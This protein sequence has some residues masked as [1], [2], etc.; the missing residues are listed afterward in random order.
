MFK[1]IP[2]TQDMLDQLKALDDDKCGV[3]C[4]SNIPFDPAWK[5]NARR[6]QAH[7][8][9]NLYALTVQNRSM[10]HTFTVHQYGKNVFQ[11][12]LRY[13][14]GFTNYPTKGRGN[15]TWQCTKIIDAKI[16]QDNS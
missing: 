7:R 1:A 3:T 9:G 11:A 5:G 4:K 6:W 16:L 10:D 13:Y 2:L 8:S 12:G 15:W 14:R